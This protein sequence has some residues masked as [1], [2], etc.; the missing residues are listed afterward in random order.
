MRPRKQSGCQA[1]MKEQKA[2]EAKI[3]VCNMLQ[4]ACG[5]RIGCFPKTDTLPGA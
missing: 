3:I 1:S 5:Q 2:G 4:E